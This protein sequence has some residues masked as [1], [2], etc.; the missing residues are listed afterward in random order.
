MRIG[1][2]DGVLFWA[3]TI[4]APDRVDVVP[5]ADQVDRPFNVGCQKVQAHFRPDSGQGFHQQVSHAHPRFDGVEPMLHRRPAS[6]HDPGSLIESRLGAVQHLGVDPATDP[7][8]LARGALR[9]D[10]LAGTGRS[11]VATY[12]LVKFRPAK[13]VRQTLARGTLIFVI[14]RDVGERR[15]L[16]LP[17]GLVG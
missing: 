17:L 4:L 12:L 13:A 10:R 6:A 7:P 2:P 14:G 8:I 9:L 15:S 3:R 1:A 11:P 5:G 16:E